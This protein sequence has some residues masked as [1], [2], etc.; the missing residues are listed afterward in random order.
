MKRVNYGGESFLTSD[1]TAD[2]LVDLTAALG[3]A[4]H[5]QVVELPI[6]G[7]DGVIRLARMVLGPA[8]QVV[9][10]PEDSLFAD[11]E[12]AAVVRDLEE[13]ARAVSIRYGSPAA[14]H[15]APDFDLDDLG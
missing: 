13:R 5:A 12:S 11:P 4:Q 1:D 15:T 14:F 9:T 6:V 7:A 2:A 8:S 10:I 3:R